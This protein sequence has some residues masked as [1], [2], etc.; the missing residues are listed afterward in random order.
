MKIAQALSALCV[1]TLVAATIPSLVAAPLPVV[2][3][4]LVL[5]G[6]TNEAGYK[7]IT[8]VLDQIGVPY[9]GVALSSTSR[10]SS[11]NRLSRMSF[12]DTTTGNGLYQGIIVTDSNFGSCGSSCLSAADW[13]TLDNYSLQYSVRLAS[14]YTQPQ[15]KW[16]LIAADSGANYTASSPLNVNLTSAG[17]TL[18]SYMNSNNAVPVG[19]VGTSSIKAYRATATAASNEITTPILTAG[20]YTVGVTHTTADGREVMALT[21]DNAPG[22]LHSAVFAYGVVNWVTKGVFLG[23]R[24]VYMNPQ[25]DDMLLGNRLYAPT[26]PQCPNDDSCPTLFAT[27]QDLQ[28]LVNYQNNLKAD[29]MFATFHSTY[30]F[31]GVGTTWFPASDP[32]FAAIRNL[33]SNFTWITH[34]WDHP[35]LDC[36]STTNNGTCI[37]ATSAQALSELNQNINVAPSLGIN[38][39][40]TSIVTPYGSGLTNPNFVNAAVQVGLKYIMSSAPPADPLVGQPS[41]I[42]SNL[43]QIPRIAP[44]L[45]DDA[46]VPQTGAYGSETDEYN[47]IFG[48]GG[49]QQQYSQKQTYAQIIDH[50]SDALL[51]NAFLRYDPCLIAFHIDNASAYD[52]THTMYTDLLDAT[53]AKYKKVFNLPVL[54]LDMKDLAPVFMARASLKSA[55]VSGVYT[56]GV[57]VVLKTTKAGTI[58]ITGACSQASCGSY[59]GQIQDGVVMS[60][61]STVTLSLNANEG[62]TLSSVSVN[63][64]AVTAGT[65]ATGTVTLSGAAP[66]GGLSVALSSNNAA[67]T[68]PGSVLV[69]AGTN[70]ATFNIA[71]NTVSTTANATITASYASATRTANVTVSPAA[72]AAL[73]SLSLSSASTVGG[74]PVTATLTLT[75]AAPSGG[76]TVG[77]SSNNASA[78]VPASVVIAAGSTNATFTITTS[79]VASAVSATIT[80]SY[81]GVSKTATLNVTAANG[82]VTLASVSLNPVATTGGTTVAGTLTLSG[83]APSGG[84]TVALSGSNSAAATQP[85]SVLVAAGA[86]TAAFTVTTKTVTT[87]LSDTITASYAGISK[88]AQLIVN[89]T[90][91][92]LEVASVSVS[93]TTVKGGSNSTGTVSLNAAAPAGGISVEL[94]TNGDPAFVDESVFIPAGA[95][96][97]TFPI[98]TIEL[99][100]DMM[101]TI[102]AFYNGHSKTA[103]ITVTKA[104]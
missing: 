41:S 31:N 15:A 85:A 101:G 24:Q 68:V 70:T 2:M 38:L 65:A 12:T 19:G 96:S 7:S 67:A 14:Y 58:P 28:A 52:G 86:T 82:S 79:T 30:A 10:D 13:T 43:Y 50:E 81:Q 8:G 88:T 35:N 66:S 60:A 9:Q 63:P 3:K 32:I 95:T 89:A 69:P 84:I 75:Q 73:S 16:G 56:P 6:S 55:G 17:S 33:G 80:A 61:N 74:T 25:I 72:V 103:T 71:T 48:P 47:A 87:T 97:A 46:S 49:S 36:Y 53:I 45:F 93:P 83:P 1:S 104:F 4:V 54:T 27:P 23:S 39:D 42:N 59:G 76:V 62:V 11:G 26:L 20:A 5:T 40:R 94:W 18:F 91:A 22:L 64:T 90:P 29:P 44:N 78:V 37:P 92:N 77:L 100:T 98:T 102:T 51:L 34:T 57:S 99:G 21:M